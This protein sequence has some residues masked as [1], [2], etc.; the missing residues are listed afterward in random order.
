MTNDD[1][2]VIFRYNV[3]SGDY[4]NRLWHIA[5]HAL[6]F[7]HV[8]AQVDDKAFKPWEHH[9]AEY[10]YMG[11]LPYPPNDMPKI[12]EPYTKDEILAYIKFCEERVSGWVDAL[13]LSA[14]ECG[15]RMYKM[16]KL[17]HQFNNLRHVQHHVGQLAG[18]LRDVS[19]FR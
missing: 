2:S 17:E 12:G 11:F 4:K 9:R 1:F 10:Q 5:Y 18:R 3:G 7:T 15:I 16:S 14:P 19:G 8:Y 6:F 13:D